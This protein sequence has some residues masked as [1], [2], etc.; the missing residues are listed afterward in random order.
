MSPSRSYSDLAL[1]LS[2]GGARAAYQGGLLRVL[3]REVPDLA[4]GI[5][6]GAA[7]GGV[8]AADLCPPP[9]PC[10]QRGEALCEAWGGA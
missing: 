4:P 3:A 8:N 2:G 1:M 9:N 5:L 10:G 6:T 7:A